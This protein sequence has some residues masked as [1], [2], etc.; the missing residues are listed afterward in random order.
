[1][2]IQPIVE[3]AVIHGIVPLQGGQIDISIH[4]KEN[5]LLVE[6]VDDGAGFAADA[7]QKN[8]FGIRAINERLALLNDEMKTNIGLKFENRQEK[9]GVS[10][11]RVTI[12]IEN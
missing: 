1:M 12:S 5:I 7:L 9:E 11:T 3:N 10:G 8:G 2:L 4:R 6:V